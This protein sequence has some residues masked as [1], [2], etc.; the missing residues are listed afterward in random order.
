MKFSHGKQGDPYEAIS[1]YANEL[2]GT[3]SR[4]GGPWAGAPDRARKVAEHLKHI[5]EAPGELDRKQMADLGEY[6]QISCGPP[7]CAGR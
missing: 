1:R 6:S 4:D 7:Q 3:F 2:S 5:A